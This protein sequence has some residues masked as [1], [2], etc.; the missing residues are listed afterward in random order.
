MVLVDGC[1]SWGWVL[2]VLLAAEPD[3]AV[4]DGP[5]PGAPGGWPF[6]LAV[7]VSCRQ[8]VIISGGDNNVPAERIER[9]ASIDLWPYD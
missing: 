5:D 6:W 7:V 3:D 1:R 4:I 8:A 2:A 9:Q